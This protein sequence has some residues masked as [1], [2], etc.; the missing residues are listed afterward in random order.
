MHAERGVSW[1][2]RTVKIALIALS[3]LTALAM[4]SACKR[5]APAGLPG[6]N[7]NPTAAA[8]TFVG[9][10]P[11]TAGAGPATATPTTAPVAATTSAP[12]ASNAVAC[13]ADRLPPLFLQVP[14]APQCT[15]D[16]QSCR[17]LCITG[18]VGACFARAVATENATN[19]NEA[20]VL[21]ARACS[22]GAAS[23]CTNYAAHLWTG[24]VAASMPCARRLMIAACQALD[25]YACGMAIRFEVE[26]SNGS[27]AERQRIAA[28]ANAYCASAQGFACSVLA[29]FIEDSM[30]ETPNP[31]RVR[32]LLEQACR[33][34]D[35]KVCGKT[36]AAA[37]FQ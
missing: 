23:G 20:T 18:D 10:A 11:S 35:T 14:D 27:P 9:S 17:D 28:T 5:R 31:E 30:L 7:T 16:N 2:G 24:A 19:H 21:F 22:L 8:P 4:T 1:H 29:K 13:L 15:A 6:A 12:T 32:A 26:A 3:A 33:S 34:G 37:A 36:T 25:P